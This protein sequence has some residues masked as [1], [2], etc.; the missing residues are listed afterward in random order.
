MLYRNI[1][2][3]WDHRHI[4][5]PSLTETSLRGAWLNGRNCGR[6][7]FVALCV[8]CG[9]L[10][11]VYIWS[12][13]KITSGTGVDKSWRGLLSWKSN[14]PTQHAKIFCC[15]RTVTGWAFRETREQSMTMGSSL[16]YIFDV[17]M[18]YFRHGNPVFIFLLL[19]CVIEWIT[20]T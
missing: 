10:L 17:I 7:S 13:E 16:I 8:G 11:P 2:I 1:I 6:I 12:R 20:W 4:C 9:W 3:L 14:S 18:E 15:I 19:N 5:G